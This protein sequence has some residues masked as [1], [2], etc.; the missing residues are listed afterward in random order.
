MAK[1][2]NFD[3]IF[4]SAE[5]MEHTGLVV[6]DEEAQ[7][8]R[9]GEMIAKS[10]EE[11]LPPATIKH[12]D[13]SQTELTTEKIE[14]DFEYAR[15]VLIGLSQTAQRTLGLALDNAINSGRAHDIEAATSLIGT[16]ADIVST[17]TELSLKFKETQERLKNA[18]QPDIVNNGTVNNIN[19][20]NLST[21]ELLKLL[22]EVQEQTNDDDEFTD[23]IQTI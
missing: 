11:L 1:M 23:N 21:G 6:V 19:I 10:V 22:N 8:I 13:I 18:G 4:N 7:V 9:T 15:A 3:A 20:G 2:S 17:L 16:S 5:P 12:S 14:K